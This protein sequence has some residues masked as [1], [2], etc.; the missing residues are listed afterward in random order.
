MARTADPNCPKGY[1]IPQNIMPS[2]LMGKE[3][4]MRCQWLLRDRLGIGEWVVNNCV[5]HHLF[6]LGFVSS[7][8]L[9]VV[10]SNYYYLLYF[11]AVIKLFVPQPMRFAF[12]I[13]FFPHWGGDPG[14]SE[15]LSALTCYLGLTHSIVC[16]HNSILNVSLGC[17]L[18]EEKYCT[19]KLWI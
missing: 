16:C 19:P 9:V 8:Q 10:V 11:V 6:L 18:Q 7:L 14:A 17:R 12:S 13:H 3:L 2:T 15:Q 5:V 4:A 1:F